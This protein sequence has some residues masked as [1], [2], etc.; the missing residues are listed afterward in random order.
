MLVKF[1]KIQI[2]LEK[3]SFRLLYGYNTPS[4]A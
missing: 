2:E 1:V 4:Y 3:L